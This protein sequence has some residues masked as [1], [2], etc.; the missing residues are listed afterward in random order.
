MRDVRAFLGF[1]GFYRY[2]IQ[3][4]SKLARPLID[5]TKK[6][7]PF[8]W[9]EPQRK[10][11]EHLKS[12]VCSK[13]ILRQP[14]YTKQFLL[15][16]DTSAYGVGAVLSQEGETNPRTHKPIQQ[17]IAYYSAT[18]NAVER[19]YDI[20]ERELLAV[21]KSLEHWRP[22]LAATS[23]PV[24][25][26]TDHANLTFWKS[27]RKVNRRVAQW[28]ATLQDYNLEIQHIPGK[29]HAASDMLSR[30]PDTN[31][32]EEDNQDL[33]LLPPKTFVHVAD[34]VLQEATGKIYVSEEH[35]KKDILA[36]CHDHPTAGHLGRDATYQAVNRTY[37]WS[38]MRKWITEYVK[39]CATCQQNKNL[40][41][42]RKTPLYHIPPSPSELPFKVVSMDLITQL[43][44]S[45]GKDAILTIV[46]HGC[47]RAATFLHCM[48]TITAEGVAQLYMEHVYRW[49]GLPDKIISDRDPRF[50][51]LFAKALCKKLHI[52]QNVSTA[53]HPQTDGLSERKN[54]WVEQF[55]RL[56]ARG[57]Q[58]DWNE[59]LPLATAV[60]NKRVN[61]TLG[62][63]PIQAL[64]GYFPLLDPLAP[65]LTTNPKTEDRAEQ[66][67]TFRQL[68]QEMLDKAANWTPPDQFKEG[69]KVW[70]EGSNLALPYQTRK[71]TPKRHGPF[72]ITKQISPVMYKLQLPPAWT[73]HDIFHASLLTPYRVMEQKGT[74]YLQPP[75]ELIDGEEEFEVENVLGHRYFGKKQDLQYLIKWKGYPTA[76]NTWEPVEQVFTPTKVQA[77]H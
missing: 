13:P 6:A 28:F 19:N 58:D 67:A 32:G 49:F 77:Y 20:Y 54:Q 12:L 48:T 25:V 66:A 40:I 45:G 50:T 36:R 59:W 60:H 68:A 62:I 65:P 74:N 9:D 76:D 52:Q 69:A 21:I 30:R 27:P 8:H 17:P 64:L 63:A 18:F 71:L 42:R 75:P 44:K 53:F 57:R 41:H 23:Q 47:T 35:T 15:S 73:I 61:A 31:K 33:V 51:S 14:D 29:L 56:V 7:T 2:F 55:L 70:L 1:T 10:A 26:L 39:G 46:D 22:H 5:L 34:E 43:P 37:W 24:K 38:G 16:T 11:F 3:S 4:Y 72:T